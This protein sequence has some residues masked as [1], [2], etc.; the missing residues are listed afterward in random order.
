MTTRHDS[1]P[2][3]PS[4]GPFDPRIVTSTYV[5]MSQPPS[6]I[7]NILLRFFF[8]TPRPGMPV[9]SLFLLLLP[10]A[11]MKLSPLLPRAKRRGTRTKS[12]KR[13]WMRTKRQR[14]ALHSCG[15]SKNIKWYA[16]P[17]LC[18]PL[19]Y[20][21]PQSWPTNRRRF[22]GQWRRSL[23][24]AEQTFMKGLI[25]CDITYIPMDIEVF[26]SEIYL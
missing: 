6:A 13:G 23:I 2:F 7:C 11:E 16:P 17:A 8:I 22:R 9:Y 12:L 19:S 3:D 25:S 10:S 14:T 18:F 4:S 5:E 26:I 21:L 20:V 1:L 24:L 15:S